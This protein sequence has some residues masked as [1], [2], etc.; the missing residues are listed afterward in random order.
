[1]EPRVV[2][3][4]QWVHIYAKDIHWISEALW[5]FTQKHWRLD[6]PTFSK[7]VRWRYR[8]VYHILRRYYIV[9][10]IR[11]DFTEGKKRAHSYFTSC[12]IDSP[13]TSRYYGSDLRKTTTTATW[14]SRA[15]N[16]TSRV[17]R[18]RFDWL[19]ITSHE[20][21]EMRQNRWMILGCVWRDLEETIVSKTTLLWRKPATNAT[22][23][24]RWRQNASRL[25][26]NN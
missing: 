18:R 14:V 20:L 23:A 3:L 6:C 16:E 15:T 24:D 8:V 4:W 7:L 13:T 19:A 12:L 22:D 10:A 26:G 11:W 1:M 25:F 21:D 9:A 2:S 5:R 17:V